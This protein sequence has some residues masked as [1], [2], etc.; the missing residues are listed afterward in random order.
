M[1][2]VLLLFILELEEEKTEAAVELFTEY[3]GVLFEL[4]LV[5]SDVNGLS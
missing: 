2:H 4:L 3:K 1:L 5:L